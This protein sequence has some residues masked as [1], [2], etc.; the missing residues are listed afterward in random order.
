MLP[1]NFYIYGINLDEANR[2][3]VADWRM[4]ID[5]IKDYNMTEKFPKFLLIFRN[6]L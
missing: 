5:F 3:V 1:I 4:L 6:V 2:N